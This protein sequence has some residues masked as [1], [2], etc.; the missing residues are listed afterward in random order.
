MPTGRLTMRRTR[1]ILRQKWELGRSHREVAE[2]LGLSAGAVA[3]TVAR[4]EAAGLSLEQ[5]VGL[6]E[7]ALE[8][9]LY[10]TV[11]ARPPSGRAAPDCQLLHAE[12]R[13]PGVTLQLLHVEYL[14]VHPNGYR[15]SQFCGIYRRWL[16]QRGLSMR[17]IHPGGKRLFV[18]YSGKKP[19]LVDPKTGEV[20]EVEL[21]VAVM[22]ASSKTFAEATLTQQGPDFIQSH[23]RAFNDFGG[24]TE[25]VVPDQLKSGVTGACRYE[26]RIQRTYEEMAT[27]YGTTVLPARPYHPKDKA[28]VEVGVQVVQRWIL[29]RLRNRTFFTLDALNLAIAELCDEL[30]DRPMRHYGQSRNQLFE[31]LDR[32]ALRPLPSAPFVYAEWK[33]CKV[34]IDYHVAVDHHFYSVPQGLIHRELEARITAQTVELFL[35]GQRVASHARS[36]A[37]GCHTTIPEHMPK[38]HQKHLEW[39]PSRLSNWAKT[40][41][42]HTQALV[43]QILQL[44]RHPAQGYRSCL[45]ILRL[46]KTYGNDRLEAASERALAAGALSYRHLDAILKNKLDRS[47]LAPPPDEGQGN[48]APHQNVRGPTYYN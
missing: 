35:A 21:F 14:Q 28:K 10:G 37:R 48:A 31:K 12:L 40:I 8:Q 5:L 38:A 6:S 9:K 23:V 7:E 2:S 34:N 27:H 30:N 42:P 16:G 32:P 24:V 13:R 19:H 17:Q 25:A 29:A 26:P 33:H 3:K 39:S 11:A 22:G 4:A 41:G 46:G 18:D 47:P 15:Y 44:R 45:G 43:D 36:F 20:R 1:E